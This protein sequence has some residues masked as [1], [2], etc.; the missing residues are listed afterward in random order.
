MVNNKIKL[1]LKELHTKKMKLIDEFNE[2]I[3][4]KREELENT[5]DHK[6]ETG[7]AT[8]EYSSTYEMRSDDM[9]CTQCGK[10]GSKEEL[11]NC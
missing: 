5:C 1:E 9:Y 4:I 8:I 10:Q 7:G 11:L 2:Q 3:K 6:N